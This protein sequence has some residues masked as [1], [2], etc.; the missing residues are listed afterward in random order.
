MTTARSPSLAY[1]WFVVAVLA[2]ANAVSF[3]DRLILSLLVQPI[4]ADLHLSDTQFGL[5]AGLAFA[6]F[7]VFM[8][9]AVAR[10]ADRY[11][12]KWIVT[13]GIAL[14]CCMTTA[15]ATAR[16]FWQLFVFRTGVG[17]GEATLSPSAY[18]LLAGYFPAN[19]LAMAIGVFSVGVSAG[20]GIAFLLGGAL[21]QWVF[22]QGTMHLPL[23][24][25]VS[26]WRLVVAWVGVLG[27][28]IALL[29][30]LVR[31]PAR[32]AGFTAASVRE[33]WQH[34]RGDWRRYS[35]IFVGYG[36]TSVTAYSV[37]TWTPALYM[38][39]YHASMAAAATTIGVVALLGGV[40]GGFLGGAY[41]D[42]LE[43]GGDANAKLRVLAYCGMGLLLP[44]VLAPFMPTMLG[45][46][47]VIFFT[48]FFGSGASGP[49]GSYIQSI[50]PDRMRAQFGAV[51][52]LS[53]TLLGA[54]LGPFAVGMLNDRFFHSEAALGQSMALVSA[55]ANPIAAWVLW[56]AFK[57]GRARL[58]PGY[59]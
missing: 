18:S 51:Y 11:S 4:K 1:A 25:D 12:R 31:E 54:T 3:V 46:A 35:F 15:T 32:A 33:V 40:L 42:R 43:R 53:L 57:A 56:Q 23:L 48:F 55:L 50:T 59:S 34:F 8:G 36:T 16:N 9:L 47:A 38:R 27:L 5:L 21:I 37:M 17:V 13:T 44:A 2:L 49:A 7:Y 10:W 24:G 39:Q 29:M 14:W 30:L 20:T 52:Q 28:P 22:A 41:A 26:G 19:R 6:I 45:H 58:S